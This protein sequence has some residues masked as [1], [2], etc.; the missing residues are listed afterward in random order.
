MTKR[1]QKIIEAANDFRERYRLYVKL[2]A[3]EGG[4]ENKGADMDQAS[5]ETRTVR[6]K[7]LNLAVSEG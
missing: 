3:T 5:V 7:L 2:T 6:E 4:W 1:E